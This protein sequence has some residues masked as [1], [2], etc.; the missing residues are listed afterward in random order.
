MPTTHI[1]EIIF[2]ICSSSSY[3]LHNMIKIYREKKVWIMMVSNSTNNNTTNNYP[4]SQ[5]IEHREKKIPWH[6]TL[7]N[8]VMSY[9]IQEFPNIIEWCHC[10]AAMTHLLIV[11]M[12]RNIDASTGNLV[13]WHELSCLISDIIFHLMQTWNKCL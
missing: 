7:E 2:I 1:S 6:M 5:I 3:V 12:P 4:S 9:Q 13:T 11:L 8:Q 10:Y